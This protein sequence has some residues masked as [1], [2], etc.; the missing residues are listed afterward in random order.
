MATPASVS[1]LETGCNMQFV[2]PLIPVEDGF[3]SDED[4]DIGDQS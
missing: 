2:P 3:D 1:N 4:D